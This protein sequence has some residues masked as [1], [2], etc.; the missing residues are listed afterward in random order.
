MSLEESRQSLLCCPFLPKSKK[1][2]PQSKIMPN[3]EGLVGGLGFFFLYDNIE[4][5]LVIPLNHIKI[6][7]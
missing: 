3:L 7:E 1:I 5:Y 4:N 6:E 2:T